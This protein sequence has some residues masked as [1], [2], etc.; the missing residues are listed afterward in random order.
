MFEIFLDI[1]KCVCCSL[2]VVLCFPKGHN[3]VPIKENDQLT[4]GNKQPA[5]PEYQSH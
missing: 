4:K 5:K 2:L 1:D 3:A